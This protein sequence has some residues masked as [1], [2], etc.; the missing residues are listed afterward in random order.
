[1]GHYRFLKH[2][3]EKQLGKAKSK[4]FIIHNNVEC[5]NAENNPVQY[6]YSTY[7]QFLCISCHLLT[8]KK[9]LAL[10]VLKKRTVFMPFFLSFPFIWCFQA[11]EGCAFLSSLFI[12]LR[13]KGLQHLSFVP[14]Q[15]DHLC[16][17]FSSNLPFM[18]RL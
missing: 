15:Q 7:P 2:R 10:S 13:Q 16:A 12:N 11:E 8:P 1:M 17:F 4:C 3:V 9:Q 5:N 6:K 18:E 14:C